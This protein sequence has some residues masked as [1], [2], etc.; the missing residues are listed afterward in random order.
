MEGVVGGVTDWWKRSSADQEGW[1]DD[2]LRLLAGG[3]K[4]VAAAAEDQEGYLD[5]ALRLAGGGVKNTLNVIGA[6]GYISGQ[7]GGAVIGA[8]GG[9]RRLGEWGLGFAGDIVLGGYAAK[10]LKVARAGTQYARLSPFQR[11][12]KY[13]STSG[14]MES[15]AKH[16][17]EGLQAF[18]KGAKIVAKQEFAGEIALAGKVADKAERGVYK[19]L[20]ATATPVHALERFPKSYNV[21]GAKGK[22]LVEKQF[23]DWLDI[24]LAKVDNDPKKINRHLFAPEGIMRDGQKQGIHGLRAY[25]EGRGLPTLYNLGPL[26]ARAYQLNPDNHHIIKRFFDEGHEAYIKSGGKEGI[27][28]LIN[29]EGFRSSA[30]AS[31]NLAD[32]L[33]ARLTKG[34]NLKAPTKGMI[35]NLPIKVDGKTAE[36]VRAMEVNKGHM[37][38]AANRASD[39][40]MSQLV[41]LA[42][43][44]KSMGKADS[45]S[46]R[47]MR[48]LGIPEAG[49]SLTKFIPKSPRVKLKIAQKEQYG[50]LQAATKYVEDAKINLKTRKVEF[51]DSREAILGMAEKLSL[52][53]ARFNKS[54][55]GTGVFAEAISGQE[56]HAQWLLARRRLINEYFKAGFGNDEDGL[57]ILYALLEKTSVEEQ[58]KK[59]MFISPEGQLKSLARKFPNKRLDELEEMVVDTYGP[60]VQ[61]GKT[62]QVKRTTGIPTNKRSVTVLKSEATGYPTGMSSDEI[63]KLKLKELK[64]TFD[65]KGSILK[66]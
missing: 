53:R 65:K 6:P 55:K 5:D 10:G 40:G 45:F 18:K 21:E 25:A 58:V 19:A 34:W 29:F 11:A 41:E 37:A 47:V 49:L 12:L 20:D 44:N 3:V 48:E 24:E 62:T 28:P 15:A 56:A 36:I 35:G 13:G 9:D 61:T 17:G 33:T 63:M 30:V 50:W 59:A 52:Q 4:N 39:M 14:A 31:A 66:L 32:R 46:R 8:L 23:R 42:A 27:N 38:A 51:Q 57:D 43:Y 7:V 1:F 26:E 16:T 2:A 54:I 60:T 22:E 64:A